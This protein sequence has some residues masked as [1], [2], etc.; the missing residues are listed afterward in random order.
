MPVVDRPDMVGGV[1][2]EFVRY[3]WICLSFVGV[4]VIAVL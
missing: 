4:V 3:M 2:M 1:W